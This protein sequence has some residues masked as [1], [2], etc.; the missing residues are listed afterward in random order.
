MLTHVRPPGR[1][2]AAA[3]ARKASKGRKAQDPGSPA[4]AWWLTSPRR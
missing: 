1:P 4:C 2:L 3:L